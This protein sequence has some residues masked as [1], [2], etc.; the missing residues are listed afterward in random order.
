M[1]PAPEM[2]Q[3]ELR[4]SNKAK[5]ILAGFVKLNLRFSNAGVQPSFVSAITW[6]FVLY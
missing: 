2:P 1:L 4:P 5:E 3:E 6:V